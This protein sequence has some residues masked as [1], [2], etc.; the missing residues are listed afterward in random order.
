M[1]IFAG[2]LRDSRS[3]SSLGGDSVF[4]TSP[5]LAC[6][7]TFEPQNPI[8]SYTGRDVTSQ[9]R[10]RRT[11]ESST[12]KDSD[13]E[14]ATEET[15]T[16]NGVTLR[17]RR[18]KSSDNVSYERRVDSAPP[19]SFDFTSS[20]ADLKYSYIELNNNRF[21]A[22]IPHRSSQSNIKSN[23][24][25]RDKVKSLA[26]K[27]FSSIETSTNATI[28]RNINGRSTPPHFNYKYK[29]K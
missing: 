4:Y 9:A 23:V 12:I 3:S 15:V 7:E 17:K 24:D 18:S 20:C 22:P 10:D 19:L 1:I 29:S 27:G 8:T 21:S 2:Y 13:S 14:K 6:P 5:P 26:K 11:S 16:K 25:G 28:T